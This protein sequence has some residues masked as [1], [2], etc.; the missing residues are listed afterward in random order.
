[1]KRSLTTWDRGLQRWSASKHKGIATTI[2]ENFDL[3]KTLQERD[4][5]VS[6]EI[7]TLQSE[8]NFLMEQKDI[9]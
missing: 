3:L 2:K 8:L 7:K 1:M 4:R 6:E 9:K 5:W